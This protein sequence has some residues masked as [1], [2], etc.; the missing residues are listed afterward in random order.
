MQDD[1]VSRSQLDE[2][3]TKGYTGGFASALIAA[4]FF[5]LV[6]FVGYKWGASDTTNALTP[7]PR[8]TVLAYPSTPKPAVTTIAPSPKPGPQNEN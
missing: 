3:Y 1:K 5:G 8:V 2:V 6:F 4:A 7:K